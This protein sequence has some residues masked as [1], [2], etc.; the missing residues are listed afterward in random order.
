MIYTWI[1]DITEIMEEK[2]LYEQLYE[3]LPD[4]RRKKADM[5][6][7]KIKKVQSI[8]VW[9]LYQRMRKYYQLSDAFPFN[10]SHSGKYALCSLSDQRGI[11][12][13]CDVEMIRGNRLAVAERFFCPQE[14]AW[15]RSRS[16][17]ERQK[18]EF[19][20]YWVLK[21]SFMKAVRLGMRL[22]MKSFEIM[23]DKNTAKLV[24][25]PE[26]YSDDYC[27][28]EY[29]TLNGDAHI[30]VCSTL[31]EFSELKYCE[32]RCIN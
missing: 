29:Q 30:A 2:E 11:Q 15:I 24:K 14:S 23:V 27:F 17:R 21:E 9:T 16:T 20:R 22:D 12:V 10:L 4:F 28:Q 8:A 1:M 5:I 7:R 13:G 18:G 32:A 6:N 3:S 19:Y 25:Q 31:N 26:D